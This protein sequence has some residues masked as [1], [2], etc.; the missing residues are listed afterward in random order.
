M[1]K[2]VYSILIYAFLIPLSSCLHYGK[3]QNMKTVENVDLKR[4]MGVWYEIARFDHS[5][6]RGLVGVKATYSLKSNGK[7]TVIN[8]GYK[9]SLTGKLKQAKGFATIPNPNET[10]RLKV[11]FFWPFGGEYL[12]LDLDENYQYAL[13]GTSSKKYLWILCRT[14]QI[15]EKVY[16]KLIEKANSLGFDTTKL[17]KV[18]QP[19]N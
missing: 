2:K 6:E 19:L 5:F 7:V 14:P 8:Q 16:L 10:G 17:I 13:I 1:V 3:A 12:I 15:D 9:D 18:S 11:Y 4:Y